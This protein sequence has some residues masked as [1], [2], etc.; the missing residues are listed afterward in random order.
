MGDFELL[1]KN[2][3]RTTSPTKK[4]NSTET[5]REKDQES[6]KVESSKNP[7]MTLFSKIF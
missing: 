3:H 5:D 1:Y 7:F 4:N 6:E 2:M